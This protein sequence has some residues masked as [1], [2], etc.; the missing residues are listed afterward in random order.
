MSTS[1]HNFECIEPDDAVY[2]DYSARFERYNEDAS[3][4]SFQTFSMVKRDG[5]RIVAGVRGHVYLKALEI[6]GLWVDEALRGQGVGA[7]I[8]KALEDEA[9]AR[10]A[11][12]AM[13]FTFSWQ[14]ETFYKRQGYVE[15]GR[16]EYPAGHARIDMQKVL[17]SP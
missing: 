6:R 2:A 16:F 13:L 11:T 1:Q 5:D 8:L 4:W 7:K 10:G 3:G 9:I 12:K 15:F 14:A 17:E